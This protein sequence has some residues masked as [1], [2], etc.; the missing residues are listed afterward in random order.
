MG[1]V[2]ITLCELLLWGRW[3]RMHNHAFDHAAG[4]AHQTCMFVQRTKLQGG[5][6]W[7][8]AT[9]SAWK[10]TSCH[11]VSSCVAATG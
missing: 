1:L 7:A 3:S 5:A 8:S 11:R 2:S 9:D 10:S 4:K 6:A